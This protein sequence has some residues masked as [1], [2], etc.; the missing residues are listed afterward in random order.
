LRYDASPALEGAIERQNGRAVVVGLHDEG[1]TQ[2]SE[3]GV[4]RAQRIG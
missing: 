1:G 2:V 3:M 4:Q